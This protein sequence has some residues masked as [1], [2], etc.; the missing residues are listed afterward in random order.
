MTEV[1]KQGERREFR[2]QT[3]K[4]KVI[5]AYMVLTEHQ[6]VLFLEHYMC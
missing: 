2:S 5:K 3:R 1:T 6:L 4:I